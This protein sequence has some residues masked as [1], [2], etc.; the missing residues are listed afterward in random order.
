MPDLKVLLIPT[1][2]LGRQP[3]EL[4]SPAAWLRAAG[5]HSTSLD[6]SRQ[7]LD[8]ETV[9]TAGLIALYLLMYTATWMAG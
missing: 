3:F 1:Y 7:S 9:R 8:E 6:L 2:E 5:F 4:A